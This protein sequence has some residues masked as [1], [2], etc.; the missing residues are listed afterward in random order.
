MPWIQLSQFDQWN[1]LRNSILE[2]E[3]QKK[4]C[5][6][7][8]PEVGFCLKIERSL[9]G[10]GISTSKK[11]SDFLDPGCVCDARPLGGV[12]SRFSHPPCNVNA[13]NLSLRILQ[14][15]GIHFSDIHLVFQTEEFIELKIEFLQRLL[16]P[17]FVE[18]GWKNRGVH[19]LDHLVGWK[20]M[21]KV[22]GN[23]DRPQG[24]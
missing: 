23:V 5:V 13:D 20:M 2:N 10:K 16:Q 3:G 17:E 12:L 21:A 7:T 9:S 14:Q 24:D 22:R 1:Q 19:W 11:R 4:F 18:A 15:V 6:S 8:L